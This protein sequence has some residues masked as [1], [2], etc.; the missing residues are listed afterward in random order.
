MFKSKMLRVVLMIMLSIGL[1]FGGVFITQAEAK[2]KSD[3]LVIAKSIANIVTLDPGTNFEIVG[4]EILNNI[5]DRIMLFEPE[6]LTTLVGGIA[7]SYKFSEDGKTLFFKIRPGQVFHSGNPLTAHDVV[8]SLRR[9]VKINEGAAFVLAQFGWNKD[10]VDTYIKAIDDMTVS[11]EIVSNLG[12]GLLLNALTTFGIVDK[13]VA[14]S[15][16]KDGDFGKAWL[17]ANSA[18]SGPYSLRLWRAN[19]LIILDSNPKFRKGEPAMKRVII[20]HSPETATQRLMLEKG[21]VDMAMELTSDQLTAIKDNKDIKIE[22]YP[23]GRVLYISLN[24]SYKPL[25]NKKVQEALHYLV[26]Y[27]GMANSFLKGKVTILQTVW[28]Y[29]SW[30]ALSKTPYKLDIEKAKALMKE[31]GYEDG[32]SAEFHTLSDSPYPEIAQ[33]LQQTFAKANIKIEI[34][35]EEGRVHWP[36]LSASNFQLAQGRWGPDY[37]D[38][39]SNLSAFV[40]EPLANEM[41]WSNEELK[42]LVQEAVIEKDLEKRKEIYLRLQERLLT[43]APFVMMYQLT[44]VVAMRKNVSGFVNGLIGTMVYYNLITKN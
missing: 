2:T 30:G 21:D 3:E 28:P 39:H 18:G 23:K 41:K 31:A 8:F 17:Q 27:D 40:D 32:F 20:K 16:E 13:Q 14:L 12:G 6:D 10:N 15:H 19:E 29:G 5:Y 38:P 4:S 44:S 35:P 37:A 34:I 24:T 33:S 43:E 42:K 9:V 11:I 25:D 26:D 1:I 36:K 7:E 22:Y